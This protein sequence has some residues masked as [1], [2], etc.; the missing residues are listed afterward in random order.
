[1]TCLEKTEHIV[2]EFHLPGYNTMLSTESQA[3]FQRNMLPP[4]LGWWM[5][6]A[7]NHREAGSKRSPVCSDVFLAYSSTVKLKIVRSFET[8]VNFYQNTW[9][10]VSA[11]DQNS[12][13]YVGIQAHPLYRA[14]VESW[15]VLACR[16]CFLS[17]SCQVGGYQTSGR[18]YPTPFSCSS[19]RVGVI[20]VG[21]LAGYVAKVGETGHG[22]QPM[23]A[24]VREEETWPCVSQWIQ[25]TDIFTMI[26]SNL[27]L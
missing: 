5:S 2:E 15:L 16:K 10:H 7:R 1:M 27:F 18:I 20:Q 13:P 24:R 14:S 3:V 19:C 25:A 4:S 9:H 8:S 23:R 6:Q 22:G 26:S 12:V 21:E 17:Y 11:S